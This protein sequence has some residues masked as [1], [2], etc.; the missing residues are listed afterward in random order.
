[1]GQGLTSRY[2]DTNPEYRTDQGGGTDQ[3]LLKM[4]KTNQKSVDKLS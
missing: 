1:M 2:R 3:K 4:I